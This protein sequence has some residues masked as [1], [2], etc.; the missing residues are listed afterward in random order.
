M[1]TLTGAPTAAAPMSSME[2]EY[3]R[4]QQAVLSL[5]VMDVDRF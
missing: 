1:R 3:E 2:K 5:I 4:S